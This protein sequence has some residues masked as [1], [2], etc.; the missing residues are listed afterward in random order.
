MGL[1][2]GTESLLEADSELYSVKCIWPWTFPLGAPTLACAL[3]YRL[4]RSLAGS[5]ALEGLFVQG[6]WLGSES[7]QYSTF[8]DDSVPDTY[9]LQQIVRV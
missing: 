1:Y 3:P 9:N 6:W 5:G 7:E 4:C 8:S 2:A